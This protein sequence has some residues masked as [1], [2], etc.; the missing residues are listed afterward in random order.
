MP[1]SDAAPRYRPTAL[2]RAL[3]GERTVAVVGPVAGLDED[4]VAA[5]L[6]AILAAAPDA[7]PALW[8]DRE[9]RSWSYPSGV[10]DRAIVQRW[11]GTADIGRLLTDTGGRP[12][13]PF[14]QGPLN[15]LISG[16]YLAVDYSHGMGDGQLG[17]TMLAALSAEPDAVRASALARGLPRT[18]VWSAL[19]RHYRAHPR[20]ARDLLRLRRRHGRAG[21]DE[22]VG[23]RVVDP[24]NLDKQS[25][26]A[27]MP[28][29]CVTALRTWAREHAGGAS[30]AAV[31][32]ASWMAAL[33][34][35]GAVVDD[36]ITV[37]VNCRRYLDPRHRFDQGNFAVALPLWVPRPQTPA[38]VGDTI[39]EV[40]DS[41]WP[42]AILGMAELKAAVPARVGADEPATT[43]T[44]PDRLRVAVSDLGRLGMF[45]DTVWA[46]GAPPQLAAYLEPAGPDA[47]SLLVSELAGG[48]TFTASFCGAMV[49][50]A[51][52]ARA[53]NMMCDDPVA[54]LQTPSR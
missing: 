2:D 54:T 29:Q 47:V 27:Y 14:G 6:R 9:S 21:D 11:D 4:R 13:P 24:S 45:G 19:R 43:V 10:D 51:V 41:G 53:L 8:P 33:R 12:L 25:R 44:V 7:R 15:V 22:A 30:P 28:P 37:L 50:P 48:R 36:R 17:V 40:I 5:N 1:P 26:T 20:A 23:T 34:A 38:V 31:T 18:A 46:P 3:A 35:A 49:E 32:V 39:R 16:D 42:I 52:V